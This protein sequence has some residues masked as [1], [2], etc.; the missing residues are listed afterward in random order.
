LFSAFFLIVAGVIALGLGYRSVVTSD[1][2][3]L[4]K[5]IPENV[6]LQ[7]KNFHFTEVGD[8]NWK[9]E[10]NA[11]TAQYVKKD[12]LAYF[13]KVKMRIIRADGKTVTIS[14][15]KGRLRTDTKNATIS[16]HVLVVTSR[17]E[18]VTTEHLN[19]ADAEKKIFTDDPV[20][21]KNPQLEIR[22]SGMTLLINQ[23]KVTLNEHVKAVYTR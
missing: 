11:D 9:W 10:I 23:E 6:D 13:T 2:E 4:L 15:D 7:I 22:A 3:T 20:T 17:G 8:V 14:G 5:I 19:Y 18:E 21:F 12:N 16:G 1:K